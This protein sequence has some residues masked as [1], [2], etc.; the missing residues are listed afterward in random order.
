MSKGWVFCREKHDFIF[1][2]TNYEFD[3][4]ET[5]YKCSKCGIIG[6]EWIDLPGKISVEYDLKDLTCDEYL[7]K[8][9]IE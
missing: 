9:I 3:E 1:Q 8:S 5:T 4:L 2:Y 6:L 7:I